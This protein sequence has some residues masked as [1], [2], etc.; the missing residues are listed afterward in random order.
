MTVS[1]SPLGGV[2]AQ[3]LDNNGIILSGGKIYTYAAGT[4]TPRATYT[5]SSGAT[6]HANPII[7]DSAGRVP[8]GEIWLTNG[9]AYKFVIETSTGILIGTYDNITGGGDASDVTYEYPAAGAVQ[10]TVQTKLEQYISVMDFGGN[11][12]AAVA[13]AGSTKTTLV[14]N[15][16][17]T[18]STTLTI[19]ANVTLR[20][21][22]TGLI[23]ITGSARLFI[24]GAVQANRIQ[25]I[26]SC[27]LFTNNITASINANAL[28]ITAVSSS[29][30]APGQIVTGAGLRD[31]IQIFQEYGITGVGTYSINGYNGIIASQAM[32]LIS[33]PVVFGA[34]TVEE[35]YPTW[36]GAVNDGVTDS[37]TA[38][39]LAVYSQTWGGTVRFPAGGYAVTGITVLHPGMIV[40]GDGDNNDYSG[41]P[42]PDLSVMSTIFVTADNVSAFVISE[43]CNQ[44][45]VRNLVFSSKNPPYLVAGDYAPFGTNRRAIRYEGHAPQGIFGGTIDSC[46]F[47]GFTSAINAN[48]TWAVVGDGVGAP[49]TYWDGTA[50]VTYYDWQVNP[51]VIRNCNFIG[52]TY[53]VLINANN[54]D[55]WRILDCIF[56]IPPS[57]FGVSLLRCGYIKLDNC[58][59]FAG[60]LTNTEFVN[61]VGNGTQ[62]LDNVTLDNCQAENCSHFVIFAAGSTNDTPPQI[63]VRN[64]IHQIDADIYL[65]SPCEYNSQNNHIMS[66]IYVDSANV[67]VNSINDKY[68]FLNFSSGPTWG[69]SVVSGDLETIYTY[70]PGRNPS[71][72]LGENAWFSGAAINSEPN[73]Q[74]VNNYAFANKDVAVII[75]RAAT[76]SVVLPEPTAFLGRRIRVVTRQ[77]QSI[78]S[79]Q[80]NVIPITGGAATNAILA[81]TAGKWADLECNGTSWVI[82][83]SN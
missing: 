62:A 39:R 48:D 50:S 59:A 79:S 31:G 76:T 81:A 46:Q 66:Y 4:T 53:G 22:N 16:A 45:V 18:L 7:L 6:P 20:F 80:S 51:L 78:I 27:S 58:F 60:N 5:S 68:Q 74:T 73:V 37:T 70:V 52:N 33:S 44:V 8:G 67:R 72:A 65:G 25:R 2:A 38:V 47:F 75:D 71:S 29:T 14:I 55:A 10:Q 17:V 12:V 82:T 61:L 28:V 23:T 13:A 43:R 15:G 40:E 9:L 11:L 56:V 36:F 26:F 3:F 42:P 1:L 34:G 54:C 64:C 19:P 69:I 41:A 24:N 57:S 35:V 63:N 21:E 32:T 77:A 83:A 30:V 49:G